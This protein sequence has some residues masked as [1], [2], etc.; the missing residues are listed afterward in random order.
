MQYGMIDMHRCEQSG[1]EESVLETFY[2]MTI[3]NS[4]RG[5][6]TELTLNYI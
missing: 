1:G 4:T 3:F 2:K 6:K 5:L